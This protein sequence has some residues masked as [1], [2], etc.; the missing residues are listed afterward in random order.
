MNSCESATH[1]TELSASI[2][3]IP[4]P[5]L[6]LVRDAK[7]QH[8]FG[9]LVLPEHLCDSL[10]PLLSFISLLATI[11]LESH[12]PGEHQNL[13]SGS[14]CWYINCLIY[15]TICS[16]LSISLIQW[17]LSSWNQ[18]QTHRKPFTLSALSYVFRGA[19]ERREIS[20]ENELNPG[21]NWKCCF[22]LTATL[23]GVSIWW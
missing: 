8:L 3:K 22:H 15:W 10:V 13:G 12:Q 5:G 16:P 11:S 7:S 4:R 18:Y 14:S 23:T 17:W 20:T 9:R 2:W 21:I 19:S 6:D 1:I